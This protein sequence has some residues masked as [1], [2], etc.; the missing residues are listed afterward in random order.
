[1]R[2]LIIEDDPQ[3]LRALDEALGALGWSV[4]L[5]RDGEEALHKL[6]T[7]PYDAAVLDVGLPVMDGLTALGKARAQGSRVPVIILTTRSAVGDR[8]RGLD[9]GA[10]DYLVKPFAIDELSARLRALLRRGAPPR[11]AVLRV[12]DL[13]YDPATRGVTRGGRPLEDMTPKEIDLLEY[14][15]RNA[16]VVVTRTMI[17]EHVWNESFESFA[18]VID[19]HITR[20]RRKLE[21]HGLPRLVHTVRGAGYVLSE[22]PP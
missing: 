12:G 11:P 18:N 1:M 17:S 5:A 15:L 19:V 10:D 6:T 9:T 16:G 22:A 7:R 3:L 20:M 2:L 8:V 4:D 13:E 14:L 21:R